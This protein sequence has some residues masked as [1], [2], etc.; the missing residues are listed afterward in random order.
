MKL[1]IAISESEM[2]RI[3]VDIRKEYL[4]DQ[5]YDFIVQLSEEQ[6]RQLLDL[7]ATKDKKEQERKWKTIHEKIG[8]AKGYLNMILQ[9]VRVVKIQI[10]EKKDQNKNWASLENVENR[11]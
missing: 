9:K 3:L 1:P 4:P 6:L 2:R 5:S 10:D 7:I 8:F 11:F